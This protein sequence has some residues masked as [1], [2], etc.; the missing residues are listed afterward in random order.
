MH[1]STCACGVVPHGL[2]HRVYN[3][4]WSRCYSHRVVHV[5]KLS[6]CAP[7]IHPPKPA[8]AQLVGA[9]ALQVKHPHTHSARDR[10]SA[11]CSRPGGHQELH[12]WF[13]CDCPCVGLALKLSFG[14]TIRWNFL[15][16]CGCSPFRHSGTSRQASPRRVPGGDEADRVQPP[17]RVHHCGRRRAG[18]QGRPRCW[19]VRD[20]RLEH[21]LGIRSRA[22]GGP[23]G[24]AP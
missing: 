17:V 19:R 16:R 3:T 22:L 15:Q 6:G 1:Q 7:A 8:E 2:S 10:M 18:P 14:A 24:G 23:S 21:S 11:H 13:G 9:C 20:R 5:T 4:R 12:T